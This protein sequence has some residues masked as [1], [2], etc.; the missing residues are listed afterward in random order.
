MENMENFAFNKAQGTALKKS[1]KVQMIHYVSKII[2]TYLVIASF[3]DFQVVFF[4]I[5]KAERIRN[6]TLMDKAL[7]IQHMHPNGHRTP[8]YNCKACQ[9]S[10]ING[11]TEII[12]TALSYSIC[13]NNLKS[14]LFG[15][16][17]D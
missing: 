10:A 1:S 13:D 8:Y 11:Y 17:N 15:N 4:E 16:S 3:E 5:Q 9:S 7:Q 12:V 2:W 14:L 6:I